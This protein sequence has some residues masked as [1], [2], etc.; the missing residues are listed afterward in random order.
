M[1][2][3]VHQWGKGEDYKTNQI[4]SSIL[5]TIIQRFSKAEQGTKMLSV[6]GYKNNKSNDYKTNKI[7]LGTC[8]IY[9]D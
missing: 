5:L 1:E 8:K 7:Y 9:K 3:N 6:G 2:E 4:Y